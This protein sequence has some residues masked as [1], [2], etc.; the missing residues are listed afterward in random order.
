MARQSCSA[1][2][3]AFGFKPIIR[4]AMI[5]LAFISATYWNGWIGTQ[6]GR[7]ALSGVQGVIVFAELYYD[8]ISILRQRIVVIENAHVRRRKSAAK[9]S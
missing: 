1:M 8:S 2:S 9:T 7:N 4:A 3:M 5:A 6:D